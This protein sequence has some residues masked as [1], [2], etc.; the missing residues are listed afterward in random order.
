MKKWNVGFLAMIRNL[1]LNCYTMR[2]LCSKPLRTE[3]D[4]GSECVSENHRTAKNAPTPSYLYPNKGIWSRRAFHEKT[5]KAIYFDQRGL[6]CAIWEARQGG[7]LPIGQIDFYEIGFN[8]QILIDFI[9]YIMKLW[10]GNA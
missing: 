2:W 7:K 10:T 1:K 6:I 3:A 4:F 9:N 8:L 5:K